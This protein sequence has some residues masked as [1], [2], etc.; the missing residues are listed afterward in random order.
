MINTTS[1]Y[2]IGRA[3]DRVRQSGIRSI[4]KIIIFLVVS[5]LL[6]ELICE[7]LALLLISRFR[8]WCVVRSR[9]LAGA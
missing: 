5:S 8:Q 4:A 1:I 7:R 9:F 2:I 3:P 6:I